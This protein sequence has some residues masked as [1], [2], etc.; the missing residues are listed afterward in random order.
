MHSILTGSIR[1]TL[2]VFGSLIFVT[3]GVQR[4]SSTQDRVR[5]DEV[6]D[7][8]YEFCAQTADALADQCTGIVIKGR[9]LTKSH[10]SKAMS[11]R[12]YPYTLWVT[13]TT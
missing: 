2:I 7:E 5:C 1:S 9:H 3:G 13:R 12:D 11:T 6:T 10:L 8:W 4:G